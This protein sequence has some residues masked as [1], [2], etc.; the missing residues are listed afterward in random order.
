MFVLRMVSGLQERCESHK[1]QGLDIQMRSHSGSS[2]RMPC[3]RA[4]RVGTGA[5]VDAAEKV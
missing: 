1:T 2:V 4:A 3:F 5:G